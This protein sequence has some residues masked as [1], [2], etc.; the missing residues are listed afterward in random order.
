MVTEILEPTALAGT[1]SD[2]TVTAGST[3]TVAIFQ[4]VSMDNLLLPN[5]VD[6]FLLPAG[7]GSF[8]LLPSANQA[9]KKLNKSDWGDIQLKDPDGEYFSSGLTLR[10]NARFKTLGPG[11]W[12]LVKT[13]TPREFGFQS[14]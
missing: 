10:H 1:S 6:N 8:L 12:R 5:G 14:E 7:A 2:V 4:G 9:S 3:N 13:A 11:V